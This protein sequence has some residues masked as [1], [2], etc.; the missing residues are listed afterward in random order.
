MTK[1]LPYENSATWPE[2]DDDDDDHDFE[3]EFEFDCALGPDGQCL[4]AGSEEC[5]WDCPNRNSE[6]F[7]GSAAWIA[8]HEPAAA[9]ALKGKFWWPSPDYSVP[10][11]DLCWHIPPS[12]DADHRCIR[13]R[14]HSGKHLFEI[15]PKLTDFPHKKRTTETF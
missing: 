8:A 15:C 4:K 3:D 13:E 9:P 11:D 5:D 7:A 2:P 14:G 12:P 10:A 1:P 6:H